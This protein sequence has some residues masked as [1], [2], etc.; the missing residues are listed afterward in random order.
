[1]PTR[2][3]ILRSQ[4]ERLIK[5]NEINHYTQ[6]DN[7]QIGKYYKLLLSTKKQINDMECVNVRPPKARVGMTVKG[8][9]NLTNPM[10]NAKA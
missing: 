3:Q 10:P 7:P 9:Y 1:M 2:L 5:F 8:L 4:R 6:S